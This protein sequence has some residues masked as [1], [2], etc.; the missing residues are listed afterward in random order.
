M[1]SSDNASAADGT[2]TERRVLDWI[3]KVNQNEFARERWMVEDEY[4]DAL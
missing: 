3:R 1:L 4:E 2:L